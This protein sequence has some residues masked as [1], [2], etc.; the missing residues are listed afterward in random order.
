MWTPSYDIIVETLTGSEF[1]VT[2]NDRDTV[3]YLK[4][5]IQ[6]YEG[7]YTGVYVQRLIV[8]IASLL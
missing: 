6:K 8:F 4:S 2:V 7:M 1:E 5:E 3:G